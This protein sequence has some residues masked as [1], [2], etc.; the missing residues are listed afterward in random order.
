MVRICGDLRH[1]CKD[2]YHIEHWLFTWSPK[3]RY[4]RVGKYES[5]IAP[6]YMYKA[7]YIPKPL[8]I[9]LAFLR[10]P[11]RLFIKHIYRKYRKEANYYAK[12]GLFN[13]FVRVKTKELYGTDNLQDAGKKLIEEI[14]PTLPPYDESKFGKLPDAL[15]RRAKELGV[16]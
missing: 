16:Y 5:L 6:I 3:I 12:K 4:Q 10:R 2:P 13:E 8:G 9:H 14:I 1:V 7:V 11:D 15:I